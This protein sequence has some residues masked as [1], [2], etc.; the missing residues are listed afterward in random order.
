ML[1]NWRV[2]GIPLSLVCALLLFFL[3][4]CS[5][6]CKYKDSPFPDYLGTVKGIGFVT[7]TSLESSEPSED[8]SS[9]GDIPPNIF[10]ML[11]F[12]SILLGILAYYLHLKRRALICFVTALVGA[13]SL[14]SLQIDILV[15]AADRDNDDDKIIVHFYP[16]YWLCLILLMTAGW[17]AYRWIKTI[18]N[19]SS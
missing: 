4:F 7:G 5:F 13:L 15:R 19:Q 10:A 18:K 11:A 9:G 2:S 12:G 16:Y 17:L 14:Y 1:T 6:H 8:S 3:P